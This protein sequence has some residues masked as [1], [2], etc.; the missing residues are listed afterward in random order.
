MEIE[1]PYH[2]PD[3][4]QDPAAETARWIAM[5]EEAAK[6]DLGEFIGMLDPKLF[7]VENPA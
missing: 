7:R 3:A 5:E 4:L 2:D 1:K 6:Q